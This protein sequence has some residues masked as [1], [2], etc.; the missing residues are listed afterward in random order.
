[1]YYSELV[2]NEKLLYPIPPPKVCKLERTYVSIKKYP[3][4]QAKEQT[5]MLSQND[6]N[7][8]IESG[9]TFGLNDVLY[10][11]KLGELFRVYH[12]IGEGEWYWAKSCETDEYGLLL[13]ECVRYVVSK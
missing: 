6:I 8:S 12:E 13:A 7:V 9:L 4:D 2:K 1:M 3:R 5:I 11:E 10:I